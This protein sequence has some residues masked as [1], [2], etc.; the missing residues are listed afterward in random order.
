MAKYRSVSTA[1][2]I[3][4]TI[5]SMSPEQKLI[6]LYLHTC[7]ASTQCGIFKLPIKT[8]GFQ[9]G[10][11][12]S[13]VES[14]LRGLCAAFPDFVAWD[15]TTGEV[16]LLQYPKQTL[17]EANGKVLSIVINELRE[18]KSIYL[19][20]QMIAQNSATISKMYLSRLRQIQVQ[21]INENNAERVSDVGYGNMVYP[22]VNQD[23]EPEIEIEIE[24]RRDIVQIEDLHGAYSFNTFWDIFGHKINRKKALS[25]FKRLSQANLKLCVD[26]VP[27]YLAYLEAT[28]VIKMH[29]T[30]WIN[31]ERWNDDFTVPAGGKRV[32]NTD[33]ILKDRNLP[34]PVLVSGYNNYICIVHEKYPAIWASECRV[35]SASEWMFY[36]DPAHLT[37]AQ[38]VHLTVQNAASLRAAVHDKLNQNKWEREKWGSVNDAIIAAYRAACAGETSGG[39]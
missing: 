4:D 36:K 33:A 14:A 34:F 29:P 7:P 25:A 18:V 3:D 32:V 21:N 35:L 2:W 17:I 22:V 5:L 26:R 23:D 39:I 13:P 16:G 11:T 9:L 28:G 15:A 24:K 30:T 27:E 20:Q 12:T 10:Y 8:A 37:P 6:F 31:G 1:I 38:R 19:L